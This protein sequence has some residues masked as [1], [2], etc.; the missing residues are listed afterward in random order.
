MLTKGKSQ[1]GARKQRQ[2][3][4]TNKN[5]DSLACTSHHWTM[6][7]LS[8]M[9]L[10]FLFF[11]QYW[12]CSMDGNSKSSP[13]HRGWI[14]AFL[15]SITI[16][17]DSLEHTYFQH[18]YL[19]IYLLY[20]RSCQALPTLQHAGIQNSNIENRKF[21]WCTCCW[22]YFYCLQSCCKSPFWNRRQNDRT[23]LNKQGK[24]TQYTVVQT[25]TLSAQCVCR[26]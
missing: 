7:K 12:N 17:P 3:E 25:H 8:D 18:F 26:H 4:E 1:R 24:G 19:F 20:S 9:C 11:P 13:K 2:Q 14:C 10:L 5:I 21:F 16:A 23:S 22:L 15:F 6:L